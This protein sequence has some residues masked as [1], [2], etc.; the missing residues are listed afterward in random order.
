MVREEEEVEV[1]N[2]IFKIVKITPYFSASKA[3]SVRVDYILKDGS[4]ESNLGII[5]MPVSSD[6]RTPLKEVADRYW[7][8]KAQLL[9]EIPK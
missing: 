1:S 9:K 8:T 2:L 6:I 3:R 5:I 7:K 4:F